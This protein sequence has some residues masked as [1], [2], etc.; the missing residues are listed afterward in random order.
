MFIQLLL[1]I[2]KNVQKVW[3]VYLNLN[4]YMYVNLPVIILLKINKFYKKK[5]YLHIM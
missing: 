5:H 4:L 3:Q 2:F 1:I